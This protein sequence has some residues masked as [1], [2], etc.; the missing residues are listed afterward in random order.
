MRADEA[1][2]PRRRSTLARVAVGVLVTVQGLVVVRFVLHVA[3]AVLCPHP[4]NYSEGPLL[5]QVLR[6]ARLENIYR[7]D[8]AHPPYTVSNYP[9]LFLLVQVPFAWLCAPAY[10]YGRLI[11]TAGVVA[12]AAFLG[13]TLR[14]LTHDRTAA[15]VGG[16]TL[17]ALEPVVSWAGLDRVDGLALGLS[18]AGVYVL[19]RGPR[20]T[21]RVVT[22]AMLLVASLYTRQSY[23]LAAPL[24]AVG[25]LCS[26]GERRRAGQL[27][28][29]LTFPT[30]GAC[31][32]LQLATHR[33]FL[34]HIVVA[35]ANTFRGA[36]LCRVLRYVWPSAAP[37]VLLSAGLLVGGR[38]LDA[39]LWG[40]VGP[41]IA[42]ATLSA[43]TAGKVGSDRNYL[44]EYSAAC[45][46]TA[47]GAVALSR[48][49]PRLQAA[50][51]LGLAAQVGYLGWH[52]QT[53]SLA[54]LVARYS[55]RGR[56]D[57]AVL[58]Q[59]IHA[60]DGP[61]LT[62]IGMGFLPLEGRRID[63]QPFEMT[64][65]AVDHHW[66]P[67]PVVQALRAGHFALIVMNT[68]PHY[69]HD[70]WPPQLRAAIAARYRRVTQL[71]STLETAEGHAVEVTIYR[72]RR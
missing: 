43:L 56:R 46:L 48:A 41:Y 27:A 2:R 54:G 8:L 14:A 32:L 11:A 16:L 12:A 57:A 9:P 18:W 36:E 50:L 59:V 51:A 64:Q 53:A 55:A 66:D 31:A 63:L 69:L 3:R 24:A 42:G 34:F 21:P 61:V 15:G 35:N 22:A 52:A 38:C 4:L 60:A 67:T 71:Q 23:A 62:D 26:Q 17:F 5:D 6:L 13:L 45:A 58:R 20:G 19:V 30:A 65:L 39:R 10:W 47:G 33:G 28:L 49:R 7:A 68:H 1:A 70:R 29:A 40:L 44:L 25:W 37:L 72:P